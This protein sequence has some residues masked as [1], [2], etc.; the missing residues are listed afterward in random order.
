MLNIAIS[1][2]HTVFDHFNTKLS[3][4]ASFLGRAPSQQTAHSIRERETRKLNTRH[5]KPNLIHSAAKSLLTGDI[6]CYTLN[7]WARSHVYVTALTK[8]IFDASTTSKFTH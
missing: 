8:V 3:E 6:A 7:S 4:T 2:L 5:T 1:I